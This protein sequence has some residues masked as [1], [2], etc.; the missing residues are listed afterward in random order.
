VSFVGSFKENIRTPVM[1]NPCSSCDQMKRENK[2][3][4]L[5]LTDTNKNYVEVVNEN[6]SLHRD[7]EALRK[8]VNQYKIRMYGEDKPDNNLSVLEGIWAILD[9]TNGSEGFIKDLVNNSIRSWKDYK[10]AKQDS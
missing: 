9:E 6:L 2:Q 10:R 5:A 7:V 3:L 8:L 1:T 4:R